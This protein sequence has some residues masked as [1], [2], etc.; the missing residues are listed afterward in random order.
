MKR[1]IILFG[2]LFLLSDC[3]KKSTVEKT[4]SISFDNIAFDNLSN[5]NVYEYFFCGRRAK[6]LSGNGNNIYTSAAI[7]INTKSLPKSVLDG[8]SSAGI[9]NLITTELGS[10][11]MYKKEANEDIFVNMDKTKFV[12]I[13]Y[14]D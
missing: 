6:I 2:I 1:K 10:E 13:C 14:P 5:L 7:I 3:D 11:F 4:M 9:I 12:M 8:E